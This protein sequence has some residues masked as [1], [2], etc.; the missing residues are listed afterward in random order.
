[1]FCFIQTGENKCFVCKKEEVLALFLQ[2]TSLCFRS[3]HDIFSALSRQATK[4]F[5]LIK[6]ADLVKTQKFFFRKKKRHKSKLPD[7]FMTSLGY[8]YRKDNR[9]EKLYRLW[10]K[11]IKEF[12]TH[13]T[14]SASDFQGGIKIRWKLWELYSYVEKKILPVKPRTIS[15]LTKIIINSWWLMSIKMMIQAEKNTP[16]KMLTISPPS[17]WRK[18][19]VWFLQSCFGI[20]IQLYTKT[21]GEIIIPFLSFNRFLLIQHNHWS[22]K[23]SVYQRNIVNSHIIVIN[24]QANFNYTRRLFVEKKH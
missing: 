4:G 5:A 6:Q 13:K 14:D 24:D 22:T 11:K 19:I 3:S 15:S 21:C 20:P 18:L 9:N 16:N 2:K 8:G 7:V 23:N 12:S 17:S 10:G 1:M